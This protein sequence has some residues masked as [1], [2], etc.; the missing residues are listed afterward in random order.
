MVET[1]KCPAVSGLRHIDG[2]IRKWQKYLQF[3]L[4]FSIIREFINKVV[5]SSR[6]KKSFLPFK[7]ESKI[8]NSFYFVA[9]Y[10]MIYN[11]WTFLQYN[12][13]TKLRNFEANYQLLQA[14]NIYCTFI[15][16][17]RNLNFPSALKFN[18]P[19][20]STG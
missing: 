20:V 4:S 11:A 15:T 9:K 12:S 14:W 3:A 7:Q 2:I 1:Q 18:N 17:L 5:I 10:K 8:S 19:V 6:C 13:Y 16:K